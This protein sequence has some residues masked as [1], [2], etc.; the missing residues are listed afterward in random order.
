MGRTKMIIRRLDTTGLVARP[1]FILL[2]ALAVL[3]DPVLSS[4][5]VQRL[6]LDT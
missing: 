1:V 4:S 2:R 6:L 5:L 3:S